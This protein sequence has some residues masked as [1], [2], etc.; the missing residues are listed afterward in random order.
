VRD[1][2]RMQFEY[3][4]IAHLV[5]GHGCFIGRLDQG[6]GW[7]RNVVGTQNGLGFL[8]GKKGLT[9]GTNVVYNVLGKPRLGARTS[10]SKMLGVS[11]N[12]LRF[13]VYCHM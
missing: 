11:Y 1:G 8:L 4:R 6:D 3:H 5:G 7:D 13:S 2:M 12:S 10:R 9:R